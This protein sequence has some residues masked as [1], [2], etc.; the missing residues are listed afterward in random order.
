MDTDYRRNRHVLLNETVELPDTGGNITYERLSEDSST[1]VSA[2]ESIEAVKL[3]G[4][5]EEDRTASVRKQKEPKIETVRDD[6]EVEEKI[7]SVNFVKCHDVEMTPLEDEK[8][9][10]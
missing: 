1:T 6:M 9:S 5:S 8:V 2:H 10:D 3:S 7:A 4:V